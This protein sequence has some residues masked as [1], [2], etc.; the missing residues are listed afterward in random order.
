[1]TVTQAIHNLVN[2]PYEMLIARWNWKASLFSST[3][4]ALIFLCANLSAGWRAAVG[5]MMAELLYR[6]VTAGFYGAVTQAL[7]DAEPP[8]A[9]A[10]AAMVLLPLVS[11]SIELTVHLLRGTPKMLASI[12]ASVCFT[13]LSTLFNLY[14]M[15]HG[16]LVVGD[17]SDS[18]VKDLRRIPRLICGFL[19]AGPLALSRLIQARSVQTRSVQAKTGG[20]NA[21]ERFAR[22]QYS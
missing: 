8:W 13:V 7:R 10:L 12:I 2:H 21:A 14:A 19:A 22:R 11:H 4:R 5:A 9:A 16:A 6:G 18:V 3:L 17:G 20:R 1:M 15:R